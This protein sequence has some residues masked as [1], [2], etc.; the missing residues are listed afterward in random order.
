MLGARNL[1][2]SLRST[3]V[4]GMAENTRQRWAP[5][6]PVTAQR[7][8]GERLETALHPEQPWR[9]L[10]LCFGLGEQI[11]DEDGRKS[12]QLRL[13]RSALA[14]NLQRPVERLA[15]ALNRALPQARCAAVATQNGSGGRS[16]EESFASASRER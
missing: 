12:A 11:A 6:A 15:P 2:P 3:T 1:H 16:T 8:P 10:E 13:P 4:L 5:A 14:L 7:V 9:L